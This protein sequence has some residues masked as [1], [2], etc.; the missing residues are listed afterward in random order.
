MVWPLKY[1]LRQPFAA[2][3]ATTG[4]LIAIALPGS[5][6]LERA[7]GMALAEHGPETMIALA[8]VIGLVPALIVAH[9]QRP[10][11]PGDSDDPN[12]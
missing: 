2:W 10:P 4:G 3:L 8:A 6:W 9:R 12:W 7:W 11:E 1:P 5:I